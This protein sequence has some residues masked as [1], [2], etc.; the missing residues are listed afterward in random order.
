MDRFMEQGVVCS[1]QMKKDVFTVAAVDN[2]DH[3][4]TATTAKSSFHGTSISLF[5]SEAT[6]RSQEA[7][8]LPKQAKSIPQ[9]PD[10]YVSVPPA[11]FTKQPLLPQEVPDLPRP[12]SL[13][14]SQEQQWLEHV[15]VTEEYDDSTQVSWS[16]YNSNREVK[17]DF[18]R[19]WTALLPLLTDHAN[20]VS[21]I[22]HS[23]DKVREATS[24]LNPG[25]T[26]VITAD[27]PPLL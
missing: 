1:P 9:L 21:T 10:S 4:P 17:G 8:S 22:K 16:A 19:S 23:M 18:D 14:L 20:E 26:P 7:L 13:S 25:Q 12:E 3:N 6:G 27:Q 11:F 2:T 24:Y 15:R 5:Q